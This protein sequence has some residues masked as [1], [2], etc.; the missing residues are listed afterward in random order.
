MRVVPSFQEP[1]QY[2]PAPPVRI[3]VRPHLPSLLLC[4][5]YPCLSSLYSPLPRLSLF[6]FSLYSSLSSSLPPLSFSPPPPNTRISPR[7][8]PSVLT[9]LQYED[10]HAL[11]ALSLIPVCGVI[12]AAASGVCV[13]V[14]IVCVSACVES[15]SSFPVASRLWHLLC[16]A[17]LRSGP[18]VVA[19]GCATRPPPPLPPP[20]HVL[21]ADGSPAHAR[22]LLP[23]LLRS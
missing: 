6:S 19:V 21:H 5:L 16:P 12:I 7:L 14:C 11:L 3:E 22:L 9:P 17:S 18:G 15:Y 4:T 10:P 2:I 23:L 13:C 8:F 20:P 1:I